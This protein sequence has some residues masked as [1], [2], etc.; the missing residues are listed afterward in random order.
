MTAPAVTGPL[1][2]TVDPDRWFTRGD[3]THAL[4]ACLRC[5]ARREC[6]REALR[7]NA[8]WGMWAGVWIDGELEPVARYLRAIA[9]DWPP[10]PRSVGQVA[11]SAPVPP[12]P[13][14]LPRRRPIGRRSVAVVVAARASGHCEVMA[15]GCKLT[16]DRQLSRVADQTVRDAS[17][18]AEVYC[19]CCSCAD[20]ISSSTGWTR[21]CGYVVESASAAARIPF[22]WRGARWVL[23][24]T[25]GELVEASE[26]AAIRSA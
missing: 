14:P 8:T 1:A 2:C 26:R 6:A 12:D 19:A 16:A 9:A 3:R 13:P 17:S 22:H 15:P 18:A 7:A 5:P 23:L 21:G 25:G 4:T 20:A 24:G 11:L 10:R